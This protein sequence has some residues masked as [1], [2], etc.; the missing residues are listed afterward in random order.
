MTITLMIMIIT[1]GLYYYVNDNHE[2]KERGDQ[3]GAFPEWHGND[4]SSHGVVGV[5]A[6]D[7]TMK[8]VPQ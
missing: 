1:R 8:Y 3:K 2:P 4:S 7:L 5:S 6:L